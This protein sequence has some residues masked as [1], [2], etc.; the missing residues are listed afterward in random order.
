MTDACYR[1]KN[2]KLFFHEVTTREQWNHIKYKKQTGTFKQT[3]EIKLQFGKCNVK[4]IVSL[5]KL[6]LSAGKVK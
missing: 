2:Y 3:F 4:N 1:K 6:N 5:S